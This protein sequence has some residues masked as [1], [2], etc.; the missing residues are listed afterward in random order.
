MKIELY[1]KT[2]WYDWKKKC[3]FWKILMNFK[4]DID[5]INDSSNNHNCA[6]F[7]MK[8]KN[9]FVILTIKSSLNLLPWSVKGKTQRGQKKLVKTIRQQTLWINEWKI[10]MILKFFHPPQKCSHSLTKTKW[11]S[12]Q[13]VVIQI[14]HYFC[15]C[16]FVCIHILLA[17][18]LITKR[19]G[20]K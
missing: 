16:F 14:I 15:M 6:I 2:E 12:S 10:F 4:F 19:V 1:I 20:T 7:L 3:W 18:A 8:S 5:V 9:N 17:R 11:F 13:Q